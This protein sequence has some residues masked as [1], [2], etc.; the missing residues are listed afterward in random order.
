MTT[1]NNIAD[2]T[3][4]MWRAL[5]A[6]AHADDIVTDE[7]LRFMYEALARENFSED[8]R[9]VLE[10]DI[11]TPTDIVTLFERITDQEDRS[12]F[13]FHARKLCWCDGDFGR[14]EQEI[15]LKLK[16]MHISDINIQDM[17]NTSAL[18]LEDHEKNRLCREME[19]APQR[20]KSFFSKLF[21]SKN[22]KQ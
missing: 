9:E 13:F 20:K 7:E 8:Q 15:I 12:R 16:K 22:K 19:A 6:L 14:Q 1:Q 2:S 17:L 5:F 21:G 18:E 11:K 4:N 10:Q 3:F